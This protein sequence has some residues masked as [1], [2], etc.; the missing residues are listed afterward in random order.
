MKEEEEVTEKEE[1]EGEKER[2]GNKEK[3][4]L[5]EESSKWRV[6]RS[7]SSSRR[8]REKRRRMK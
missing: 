1:T 7:R 6:T 5:K 3:E 2:E 8:T 4:V